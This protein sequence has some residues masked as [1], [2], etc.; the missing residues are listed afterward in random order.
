MP[1]HIAHLLFAEEALRGA[2]PE[3]ADDL[4]AAHGNFYRFG[5]QGPDIFYH[6]QRTMPTGLRYGVALHK[7]GYG[8]FVQGMVKEALRLSLGP[9]TELGAFIMGFATH[10]A[11]DRKAHPFINFFAGWADPADTEGRRLYHAHPFLERIIDVLVLKQRLGR[12]I[13]EFD[14]LSQVQCGKSL[15]YPVIKAMVKSLNAV[16][17]QYNFKS[18]N[19]QR[20]ENAYHDA[21]SFWKLTNHLNP[22][23]LRLAFR[24]EKSEG[25]REKRLGLLHPSSLPE[26]YDFLNLSHATWCH[27]C[28]D[29]ETSTASLLDLYEQGL[30]A[31][32]PMLTTIMAALAGQVPVEEV[33]PAVGNAGL[34]TGREP[35]TPL[36]SRPLPLRE[37]LD[38]L[39]RKLESEAGSV[40]GSEQ[41]NPRQA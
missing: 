17:P 24:K 38:G 10:A 7:H 16:Y 18:R 36:Y 6:N 29:K 39:Y 19:R 35:C 28:D 13:D 41:V 1:S 32:R 22:E 12:T 25:F 14:Y 21:I 30:D 4:L 31:A 9:H 2:L 27:P 3:K 23:L 15:P 11:L 37:I 20:V 5:A 40:A 33:A 34:D 26:G 8:A